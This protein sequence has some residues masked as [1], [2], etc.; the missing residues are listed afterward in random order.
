MDYPQLGRSGLR[1]SRL[2]LGTTNFGPQTSE[3]HSHAVLDLAL[4]SGINVVDTTNVCGCK[5]GEGWTE[6]ILGRWFA[7]RDFPQ[8]R[9]GRPRRRTPGEPSAP[10]QAVPRLRPD[11]VS[12]S[13][14]A[15][16]ARTNEPIAST[17]CR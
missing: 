3:P 2:R 17:P 15:S 9:A 7:G 4:D 11:T 6:Q 5:T 13:A 10:G 8:G 14:R 1:A 16:A 12:Y